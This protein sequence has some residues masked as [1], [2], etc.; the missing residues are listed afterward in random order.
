MVIK[1]KFLH[2]D[3]KLPVKAFPSDA[4]F[5]VFSVEEVL[6]PARSRAVVKTGIAVALPECKIEGHE[7][8]FRVAPRSGLSVKH[9]LDV[10]AGVV[11][12][13]Y[14]GELLISIFNSSDE[15]FLVEKH[16]RIA[17][18]IPT[19]FLVDDLELVDDLSDS[20]R[21]DNGFGSS[22]LK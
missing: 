11:D 10:F 8:Y 18:L 20:Y 15:D 17:Q 2:P 14:R 12:T 21:S 3:A 16:M 9:G 4:G 13:S 5:D 7:Y 6:I 1:V 22:G 19:L